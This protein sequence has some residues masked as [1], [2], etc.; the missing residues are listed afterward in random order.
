MCSTAAAAAAL[1]PL[2]CDTTQTIRRADGAIGEEAGHDLELDESHLDLLEGSEL[3]ILDDGDLE[4]EDAGSFWISCQSKVLAAQSSNIQMQLA[5]V[6]VEGGSSIN[7]ESNSSWMVTQEFDF[8][9]AQGEYST[10]A[11]YVK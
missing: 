8:T 10:T 11:Q 1:A 4:V 7:I 5:H 6:L 9:P 2:H 3:Q